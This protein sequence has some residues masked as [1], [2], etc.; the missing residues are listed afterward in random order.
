MSCR[1]VLAALQQLHAAN[2]ALCTRVEE[3]EH[4]RRVA[5]EELRLR[6]LDSLCTP[7]RGV[8]AGDAADATPRS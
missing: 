7:R 6:H 8:M 1:Q 3:A 4:A 2:G 5:A